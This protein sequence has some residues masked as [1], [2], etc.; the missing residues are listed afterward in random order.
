MQ[1]D[2]NFFSMYRSSAESEHGIDKVTLIGLII[3]LVCL[4]SLGAIY[5]R[6]KLSDA[7]Y[8]AM[9]KSANSYLQSENVVKSENDWNTYVQK[10][11]MLKKYETKAAS[12]VSVFKTLP[13]LDSGLLS[14]VAASMP[15]DVKV[16][17]LN[18]SG[19]SLVFS[20]TAVDKL[21]AANFVHTLKN[22]GKFSNVTYAAVNQSGAVFSFDVDCVMKAVSG[23]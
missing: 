10:L 15:A 3:L 19:S 14:A 22:T 7:N 4:L 16:N 21:S 12:E 6:Y 20:C 13:V 23:K 2:V 5:A 17:T 18:Y 8:I 9:S 1:R 11:S